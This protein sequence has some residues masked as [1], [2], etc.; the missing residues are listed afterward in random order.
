[1]IVAGIILLIIAY[2]LPDLVPTV[3]F[4]IL[5]V[6]DV[7]GWILIVVGVILLILSL[8]GH[9]VGGRRYWF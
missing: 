7:V 1:M 9:P 3:P 5:H 4:S 2:V 6:C 8:V